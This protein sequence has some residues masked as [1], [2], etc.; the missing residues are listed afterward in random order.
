MTHFT[1]GPDH[2]MNSFTPTLSACDQDSMLNFAF[3]QQKSS[4]IGPRLGQLRCGGRKA[5][6][7]PNYVTTTSRGVVPHVSHD[8]LQRHTAVSSIYLGLEDCKLPH[9]ASAA[10]ADSCLQFPFSHRKTNTSC[11]YL[12]NTSKRE[13]VT[14]LQVHRSTRWR[15]YHSRASTF[16]SSP[17]SSPQYWVSDIDMHIRGI[18]SARR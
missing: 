18:Q 11:S 1:C 6:E 15:S 7:T 3:T 9:F 2:F 12:Q 14:T 5:I 17:M 16:S 10:C 4:N 8:T 13:G